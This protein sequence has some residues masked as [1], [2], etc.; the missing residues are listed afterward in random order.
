MRVYDKR[1]GNL[2]EV[3]DITYDSVGYPHFLIYD[4]GQWLRV[5]AKHFVPK[6]DKVVF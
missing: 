1:N 4:N 2:F 6:Y 3:Y 5:S